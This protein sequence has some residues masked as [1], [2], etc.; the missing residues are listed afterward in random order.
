[1]SIVGSMEATSL[2]TFRSWLEDR[3]WQQ[4]KLID[5]MQGYEIPALTA[6]DDPEYLCL[7]RALPNGEQPSKLTHELASRVGW[8]LEA[9]PDEQRPGRRP[10]QVLYNLLML[11]GT[12]RCPEELARPLQQM[13]DRGKLAGEWQGINLVRCLRAALLA[14]RPEPEEESRPWRG[15]FAP[16]YRRKVLFSVPVRLHTANLPRRKPH[17]GIDFRRLA[18]D[19]DG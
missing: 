10:E 15:V 8:I 19:E 1:M 7:L 16:E 4:E 14:N 17:T 18:R 12:L 13:L 2:Q 11:A 9:R 3:D 5:W 6:E